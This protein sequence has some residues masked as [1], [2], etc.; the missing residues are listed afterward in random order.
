MKNLK[1]SQTNSQGGHPGN[2][3]ENKTLLK[4]I[5]KLPSDV[6]NITKNNP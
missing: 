5:S 2:E 3:K 4:M 1:Y 6:Y